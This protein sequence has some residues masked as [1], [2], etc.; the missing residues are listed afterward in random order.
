MID[1]ETLS[2]QPTAYVTQIGYCVARET[3]GSYLIPPTNIWVS[4]AQSGNVDMDTIQWWMKQSDAAR[5]AVFDP[6]EPPMSPD[7]CFER[8][9]DVVD[10]YAP[11]V[12]GSPA[13]YDLPILTNMWKGRK[14]WK[15]NMER[16]M[17][18]LYKLLDP[19][20]VL[21]PPPNKLAHDAASDADWQMQY[22]LRLLSSLQP[23]QAT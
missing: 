9:Q 1:I 8:L 14:P 18:T 13:M 20:G 5:N 16:D 4:D 6:H 11:Q 21:K 22:L 7:A 15:Y 3:S 12:W 17:M 2:L 23:R 19:N 10:D